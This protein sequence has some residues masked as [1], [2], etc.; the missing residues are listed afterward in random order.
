M[1]N[2]IALEDVTPSLTWHILSGSS[3]ESAVSTYPTLNSTNQLD[4]DL[5]DDQTWVVY[6]LYSASIIWT[7]ELPT[8]P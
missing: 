2:S 3:P 6:V 4:I 1:G 5:L 8:G 7:S